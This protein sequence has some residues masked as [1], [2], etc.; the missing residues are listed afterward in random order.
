MHNK[1]GEMEGNCS[2]QDYTGWFYGS[3]S[4]KFLLSNAI[5]YHPIVLTINDFS[6]QLS[7]YGMNLSVALRERKVFVLRE[8]YGCKAD[9]RAQPGVEP[10]T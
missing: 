8:K 6:K 1:F 9:G 2:L 10:L 7:V 4:S 3:L 5:R